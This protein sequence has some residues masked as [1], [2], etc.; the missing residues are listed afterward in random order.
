M[1]C[2]QNFVAL[3]GVN[4]AI[5]EDFREFCLYAELLKE[6]FE[7]VSV[8]EMID[9][10]FSYHIEKNKNQTLKS[11][12]KS[13]VCKKLSKLKKNKHLMI[14]QLE[15]EEKREV[16]RH[17]A[18]L[19]MANLYNGRDF[20]PF[21]E[22]FD[23]VLNEEVKIELDETLS[24]K[25]NA[26]KFYKHYNK[27]KRTSEKILEMQAEND[28]QIEY[29][30]Q[31]L[32]AIECCENFIELLDIKNEIIPLSIAPKKEKESLILER[33][34]LGQ[35]VFIGRNNKQND[36][37]V[38]KLAKDEDW[39]FHTH[40]CAGSHVLLKCGELTDELVFECAKLAK[41]FSSASQTSKVGVIYTQ[42]KNIKKP[43]KAPLG[44][45]IYKGEE[46]IIV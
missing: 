35:K 18:D 1:Q 28:I 24:L 14:E 21:I 20:T 30:E 2:L 25:D 27:S 40:N 9:K 36:F 29:L 34:I 13:L 8:N 37:I 31:T 5:S 43:P 22:V 44:Y 46:E 3:E 41:E 16:Y 23:W 15:K 6:S 45:V 33:E 7:C 19:I 4:P 38:S 39:W 11:E 10:Y 42:R 26:N 32:Y 17:K 12:L